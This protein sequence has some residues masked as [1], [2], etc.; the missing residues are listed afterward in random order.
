MKMIRSFLAEMSGT[1]LKRRVTQPKLVATRTAEV[2]SKP[3]ARPTRSAF[4]PKQP[5]RPA[6]NM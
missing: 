4:R 1:W 6:S 5:E 3:R 2:P